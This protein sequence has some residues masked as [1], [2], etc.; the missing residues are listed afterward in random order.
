[1]AYHGRQDWGRTIRF[2]GLAVRAAGSLEDAEQAHAMAQLAYANAARGDAN[3]AISLA[4]RACA[5]AER[6]GPLAMH[7]K[8][9]GNLATIANM[10]RDHA[11]AVAACLQAERLLREARS[12]VPDP[13]EVD[14]DLGV[15]ALTR[16]QAALALGD[17]AQAEEALGKA[18]ESLEA[19][20]AN[21][22]RPAA[23]HVQVLESLLGE[24]F[25]ARRSSPEHQAMLERLA[26]LR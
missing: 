10:L 16:T 25:L 2:L 6:T 1:M 22:L 5:M 4:E 19:Q 9:V 20:K 12:T 15:T 14:V 17:G 7:A 21:G 23:P 18:L 3:E 26:P 11:R 13:L 24:V 8:T